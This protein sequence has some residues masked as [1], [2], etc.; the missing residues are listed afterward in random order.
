MSNLEKLQ[1][2]L[3]S[4][5]TDID[6]IC[7]ENGLEYFLYAGTL[8]GS[9]RHH[10]H[11]PW[12]DDIDIA[13]S[14]NHYNK[15]KEIMV[16]QYSEKYFVQDFSTE[17]DYHLTYPKIRLNNTVYEEKKIKN[18]NIHKGIFVDIFILDGIEKNSGIKYK[19]TNKIMHFIK[20]AIVYKSIYNNSDVLD[21][22]TRAKVFILSIIP[23]KF[24]KKMYLEIAT[25]D[26]SK[27][28]KY[29]VLFGSDISFDKQ[30][31]EIADFSPPKK[32]LFENLEVSVPAKYDKILRNI[33]GDYMQIPREE[34]RINHSPEHILYSD[35]KGEI[36]V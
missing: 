34:D 2:T 18:L 6:S 32:L 36:D 16:S 13:M 9:V 19:I 27:E 33:Y 4:I 29:F 25:L 10:G 3:L 17:K 26:T 8:I 14:R 35:E 7:R 1:K 15:L 30:T 23:I 24:L 20:T 31:Y 12:D 22:K 11:I 21:Y 28:C 5:L